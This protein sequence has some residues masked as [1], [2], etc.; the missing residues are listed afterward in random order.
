M[1]SRDLMKPDKAQ[2]MPEGQMVW[3][4]AGSEL[5]SGP[6][7]SAEQESH[8]W[9]Y[10]MVVWQRR[11]L[12]ILIF[13][14]SLGLG[15]NA[16]RKAVP[17]YE[18]SAKLR[19]KPE[20]P[21][22]LDFQDKNISVSSSHDQSFIE[23]QMQ[24]LTSRLLAKKVVERLKLFDP[25]QAQAA[26]TE[27]EPAKPSILQGLIAKA[28]GFISPVREKQPQ[29]AAGP[30]MADQTASI[31]MQLRVDAFLESLSVK[32]IGN[33]EIVAVSYMSPNPAE[34]AEV[35]NAICEDYIQ[36]TFQSEFESFDYARNWLKTKLDEMKAK[37]EQSEDEVNK[38]AST[39]EVLP[40][41]STANEQSSQAQ[42]LELGRQ[43]VEEARKLMFDKELEKK[44]LASNADAASL[45]ASGNP[46]LQQ[47]L[48]EFATTKS[49]YEQQKAK[50]GPQ[51][52]ELKTLEIKKNQL[53]EQIAQERAN[54]IKQANE[55]YNQAKA[56][57][58]YL[59]TAAETERQH[60]DGQKQA[61]VK[62]TILQRER[63][64][65]REL[66][67]SLLQRWKEVGVTSGIKAGNASLVEPAV[68]PL[69]SKFPNKMRTL[70]QSILVGLFLGVALAFFLEYMDTSVKSADDLERHAHL[71]TLGFVPFAERKDL[72]RKS[73]VPI[74]LLTHQRPGSRFAE[75]IRS[76]RT[77]LQYSLA[78]HPPT[79]ILITSCFP[80]EG[81][82]TV[83]TNLAI[84]L[85]QR[86]KTVLLIDADLKK[87]SMQKFFETESLLG[88][89][90]VLTGKFDGENIPETQISNLFVMPS[91]SPAP[92]PVDLLDSDTMR[93]FLEKMALQYDHVIIDAP[94]SI[95]MNDATVIAP[96]VDGVVLVVRPGKT[97]KAAVR[98]VRERLLE[99]QGRVLG[100]V[101]NCRSKTKSIHSGYS[102]HYGYGGYNYGEYGRPYGTQYNGEG[103][104]G[105]GN[106]NGK[107]NH[108]QEIVDVRVTTAKP[109][110]L[111][112]AER[113]GSERES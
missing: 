48:A 87:P 88:L 58:D 74:A 69:T 81:K 30:A 26:E 98:R 111:A 63:D 3:I 28:R 12:V 60:Y 40:S 92:N 44:R 46:R 65:N 104:H 82:T 24:I 21:K 15:I 83:A 62:Y 77:S 35:A 75:S 110:T 103:H 100:A 51:H 70:M 53:N 22:I 94:P 72:G 54:A 89:T 18:T 106:G 96:H 66:Y 55:E 93:I 97:P 6:P 61:M 11:W 16:T 25:S 13:L 67:N 45:G 56:T 33:T 39:M 7:E 14:L 64:I 17:I 112:S 47:L 34:A 43:K 1:K 20:A 10:I 71:P 41:D 68:T 57:F 109:V 8:L 102:H 79:T 91:G 42:Q 50:L 85:A 84:T 19:I 2:N 78:G 37:L 29:M 99:V 101:L 9:D 38:I 23:T 27:Q 86:N 59:Q 108:R 4:P 31:T 52:P 36:W 76:L 49:E 5:V 90:E 113:P 32:P 95:D 107:H 105:N 73:K 80:N